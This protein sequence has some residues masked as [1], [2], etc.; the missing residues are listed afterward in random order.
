MKSVT[1]LASLVL[2][3]L[4]GTAQAQQKGTWELGVDNVIAVD[5][6]QELGLSESRTDIDLIL[7]GLSWRFGYFASPLISVEVPFGLLYSKT[8]ND[9][10]SDTALFTGLNLLYSM[11]SGLFLA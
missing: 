2:F 10:G 7:P 1:I 6:V 3:A 9:G 4:V 5:L 11:Q 8:G